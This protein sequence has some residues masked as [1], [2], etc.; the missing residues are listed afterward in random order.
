MTLFSDHYTISQ[1]FLARAPKG[2]ICDAGLGEITA[3]YERLT[4]SRNHRE[5]RLQV[6]H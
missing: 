1:C 4:A 5:G 6:G 3:L 2:G